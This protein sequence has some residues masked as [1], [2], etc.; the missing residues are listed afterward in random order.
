MAWKNIAMRIH[1]SDSIDPGLQENFGRCGLC[2]RINREIMKC[3]VNKIEK[4]EELR[5]NRVKYISKIKH[6]K[7]KRQNETGS[8]EK[9]KWYEYRKYYGM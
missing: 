5:W 4:S 7:L 1:Q 2:G 6:S 9:V 8:H 3:P